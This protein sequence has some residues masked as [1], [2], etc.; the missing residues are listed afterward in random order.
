MADDFEDLGRSSRVDLTV[1]PLEQIEATS[2]KLPPPAFVPQAMVP[3][4]LA[5]EWRKGQRRVS[6]ET[7]GRV[8]VKPEKKWNEQVMGVPKGLV[9]LLSYL[10]VGGSEHHKHAKE[11]DMPCY[12]TRLCVVY[13]NCA[14]RSDLVPFNVEETSHVSDASEDSKSFTYLT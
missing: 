4:R 5:S 1:Y 13:L 10:D 11:H 8:G 6:D 7:L 9:G 2:P 3:E 14:L 12:A